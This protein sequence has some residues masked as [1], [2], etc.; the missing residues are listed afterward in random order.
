MKSEPS[1]DHD[2]SRDE[3]RPQHERAALTD[4]SQGWRGML[5]ETPGM[6]GVSPP[7]ERAAI[8]DR[9]QRSAGNTS[10]LRMLGD[11]APPRISRA[12][13]TPARALLVADEGGAPGDGRM[14]VG[15]F[16][17][18]VHT[19]AGAV[20]EQELGDLFRR[21]GC[22]WLD[23]W[24]S[25]YRSQ[26]PEKI[27]E[28]VRR[29]APAAARAVTAE[30]Y[31]E[32]IGD[33]VRQGIAKWRATR[34]VPDLPGDG[35]GA[36]PGEELPRDDESSAGGGSAGGGPGAAPGGG[37][38]APAFKLAPGA[39]RPSGD[40]AD[41]ARRLGPGEPL[42]GGVGGHVATAFGAD[43]AGVRIHRDAGTAQAVAGLGAR[44]VT[45]GQD[46]AFAP[47]EYEPG[48]LVGDALI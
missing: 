21:R 27:E 44:A 18:A 16:L 33:R 3:R 15:P 6:A 5:R 24:I 7:G 32:A 34:Q 17:D 22:P 11:V 19:V 14:A 42:D 29:Y 36:P 1:E 40:A 23:H 4:V 13:A 48:T 38:P 8:L 46:I 12:P 41:F 28:A 30:G 26:P 9:L 39:P 47:G 43:L 45:V 20:A 25:Y 35:P 37:G 31:I 2:A 10:V